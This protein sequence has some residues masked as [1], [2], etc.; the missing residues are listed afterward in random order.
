MRLVMVS[1]AVLLAWGCDTP[2]EQE[3]RDVC[4]AFCRCQTASPAKIDACVD[5]C[6]GELPALPDE[7]VDCIYTYSQS[8][9]DLTRCVPMCED[10][11]QP[12]DEE[13]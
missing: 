2:P 5:E 9:S 12:P 1:F 4:T 8:C 7:C 11:Q 10:T 6:A 13:L 3:A